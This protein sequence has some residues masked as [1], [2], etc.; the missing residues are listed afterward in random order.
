MKNLEMCR[1]RNPPTQ[2]VVPVVG[3]VEPDSGS[4]GSWP[5]ASRLAIDRRQRPFRNSLQSPY[6]VA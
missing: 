1:L 6:L 2:G 3:I 4:P 5:L